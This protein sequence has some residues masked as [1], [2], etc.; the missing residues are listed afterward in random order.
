[1][2]SGVPQG[3]VLEPLLFLIYV[4]D[5]EDDVVSNVSGYWPTCR[6][7]TR[8]LDDLRTGH[9]ANLS[10]R[11]LDKLQI[12]QLADIT[13]DFMCLV[14]VFWLLIDVFLRVYINIYYGF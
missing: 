1:V 8:K 10:T 11:R 5:L 7:P 9:L 14:F 3:S 13:G 2:W 12:G 6:L 4:N